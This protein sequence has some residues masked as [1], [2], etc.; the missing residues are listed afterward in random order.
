MRSL[1]TAVI[2]VAW[3]VQ[4]ATA[5]DAKSL[6]DQNAIASIDRAVNAE[7]PFDFIGRR[8]AHRLGGS[9]LV[10][11]KFGRNF[12]AVSRSQ[13]TRAFVVTRKFDSVLQAKDNH[14]FDRKLFFAASPTSGRI[15]NGQNIRQFCR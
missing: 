9:C 7:I 14:I 4:P 10:Y 11:L 8:P 2:M 3:L 12:H 1:M 6:I 13:C 5:Q 15:R